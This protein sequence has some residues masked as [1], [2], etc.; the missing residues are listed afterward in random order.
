M[1]IA[2]IG[3]GVMA[4]AILAA[5]LKKRLALS[6]DISV[7]DIAAARRQYLLE[8]YQVSA[9]ANNRQVVQNRDVIVLSVKPQNISDV[10]TDMRGLVK[11]SQLVI[12]IIAGKNLRSIAAGL[13]HNCIVRSMPNTPA[14][15]GEGITVWTATSQVNASQKKMA[16]SIL[17]V[18]G[19]EIYCADEKYL[20]MATAISG[21]G[22]AYVFLFV[23][24]LISAAEE[25]GFAP[26]VA[27]E[28]VMQTLLG[29]GHLLQNSAKNPR[30]L[31]H[32]VTSPGGTTA[33]AIAVFEK[34]GFTDLVSRAVMAAY[35]KAQKLG[36]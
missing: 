8:K 12:S 6:E 2:F 26:E 13:D 36:S 19:K 9:I 27:Q 24:S 23:E 11:P 21:S 15:I 16:A 14:Q 22:P 31:R 28:L 4:E 20:D 30:D 25:L 29:S 10:M 35:Q 17:G 33:E 18:M 5:I 1:K 7:S 3:G 34:G 32:M